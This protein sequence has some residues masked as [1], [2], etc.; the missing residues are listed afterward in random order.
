MGFRPG[1]AN[2]YRYVG[3]NPTNLTDPT[4]LWAIKREFKMG[5]PNPTV[6]PATSAEGD[7]IMGL[8]DRIGL[9]AKEYKQWMTA[10]GNLTLV[11]GRQVPWDQIDVNDKLAAGQTVSVPNTILMLWLGDLTDQ[12]GQKAVGWDADRDYLMKQGYDVQVSTLRARRVMI[13][14]VGVLRLIAEYSSSRTLY[15]FIVTG[16]GHP[17]GFS[18][19]GNKADFT[20]AEV[21]QQLHY[22]LGPVILN[23]CFGGHQ[24]GE[25]DIVMKLPLQPI[26][27]PVLEQEGGRDLCAHPDSKWFY[28][29]RRIL[30]PV[31]DTQHPQKI[32]PSF[33]MQ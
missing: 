6:A 21:K 28:G 32:L 8:A 26:K 25:K 24:K 18:D 7:T 15:G 3:N 14:K 2:L 23:V 31:I 20:Y 10:K 30:V 17:Y 27:I 9:A 4:G 5:T 1:D 29:L 11:G 16:H 22:K 19:N 33:G 12:G 13:D